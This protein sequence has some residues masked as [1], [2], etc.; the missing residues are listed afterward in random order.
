MKNYDFYY[1]YVGGKN[2]DIKFFESQLIEIDFKKIKYIVEPFGGSSALSRYLYFNKGLQDKKYLINDLDS[3]LIDFYKY[4]KRYGSKKLIEE[5]NKVIE[6]LDKDKYKLLYEEYKTT[7]DK[8]RKLQLLFI[9]SKLCFRTRLGL[10]NTRDGRAKKK[11]DKPCEID[12]FYKNKKVEYSNKDFK[13]ILNKYKD[14]EEAFIFLDPPYFDSF[15]SYYITYNKDRKTKDK[16]IIDNT[17]I[18]I[19]ILEFMKSCKCKV[20]LIINSNKIL[21]HIYK[22]FIKGDYDK[23]YQITKNK[24]KHLICTN[25]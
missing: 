5:Y 21:E 23:I 13:E 14:N 6:N 2:R 8:N 12:K 19:D 25:Y 17:S 11:I 10:L 7:T 18:F 9:L 3:Q 16:V 22:D 4:V 1:P 24:T 20:M 15:N